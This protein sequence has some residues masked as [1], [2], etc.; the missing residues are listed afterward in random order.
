MRSFE[1]FV[2]DPP[3]PFFADR[4]SAAGDVAEAPKPQAKPKAAR[5]G[6][7]LLDVF[8]HGANITARV[9]EAQGVCVVRD[10]AYAVLDLATRLAGK[11]IVRFYDDAYEL[12][13]ERVGEA[14]LVS[15]YKGGLEPLVVVYDRKVSFGDVFLGVRDALGALS[16]QGDPEIVA[17]RDRFDAQEVL[18]GEMVLE[19]CV[20]ASVEPD[21][22]APVSFATDFAVRPQV[23]TVAGQSS[24]VSD[25]HALLFRGRV[26]AEIRGRSVELGECHPFLFAERILRGAS[27][28]LD[29]WEAGRE[30][31]IRIDAGGI[32]LRGRVMASG[33][34]S[35]IL[36]RDGKEPAVY[37]FPGLG[38]FDVVEAILS[39][40][41][42]LVRSVLRRDR[43]QGNNLRFA[44]FRRALR[45]STEA[46]RSASQTDS[47]VNPSPESYRAFAQSRPASSPP[48]SG[49]STRL[50]YAARWRAMVPGIDLRSTFLCGSRLLVGSAHETFCLDRVTGAVE[51]RMPTVRA[52]SVVTPS[53]IARMSSDGTIEIHDLATGL[54]SLRAWVAP[55]LGGPMAGAVIHAPGL[56]RLLVVTEGEKHLVAID[57]LSGE[58]RWRYAWGGGGTLRLKRSGK[59]LYVTCGDSSLTALDVVSG[60]VVWRTRDRLRF[61]AAPTVD[62][63]AC[64]AVSGGAASPAHIHAFDAFSGESHFRVSLDAC[65]VE[66]PVLACGNVLAVA[67]RE[68][69]GLR[70]QAFDRSS[71][72]PLWKT[73]QIASIG[74]SWL[75]VDD[76]IIG[77][78]PLGEVVGVDATRG[79]V[80][81]RKSLGKIIESD[82]PRR[83]EPVLRSGA[84]FVPHSDI[85][86]IRPQD[87]VTIGQI[88]CADAIPDLLRVDERCDVY[89]AEESGHL[90]S[91]GA[92]AKLS[93]VRSA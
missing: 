74:T 29:A 77:N 60:A 9:E 85:H 78:S 18:A 33:E 5:P 82:V 15:L 40:G 80:A 91:F 73:E 46:L 50:R 92:M 31:Q 32:L 63:D 43:A 69:R 3:Q 47:K 83:L 20:A 26:R 71:G 87:G 37:T 41:R 62:A 14:A 81:Y 89:V 8:L 53:G 36:G 44:A 49:V 17:L 45:E 21:R 93:L 11:R 39:F 25:L 19:E 79:T 30:R 59:L 57:L 66:G 76:R 88:P 7:T 42:G 65:T 16:A 64:F 27:E 23:R 35:L 54:V 24:E 90:V 48:P 61:R 22:D 68:P 13:L 55:R 51:W 34:M 84:L 12:C 67:L 58:A 1:I 70:L 10:M 86:V 75:C 52:T 28:M 72:A 56:P 6:K 2:A 4:G 38:L